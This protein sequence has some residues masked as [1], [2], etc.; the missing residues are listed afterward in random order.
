[1][2]ILSYHIGVML[3]VSGPNY[4]PNIGGGGAPP[5]DGSSDE[6]KKLVQATGC[7]G[8]CI[9]KYFFSSC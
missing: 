3:L 4:S 6:P 8:L 1:M 7:V 5:D 9:G 2:T